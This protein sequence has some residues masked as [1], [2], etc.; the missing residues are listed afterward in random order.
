M[1]HM[2]RQDQGRRVTC[3]TNVDVILRSQGARGTYNVELTLDGTQ[4]VVLQVATDAMSTPLR[5]VEHSD[6]VLFDTDTQELT[7]E[8]DH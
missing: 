2:E 3:V 4:A 5:I 6:S 7:F 1:I 8:H